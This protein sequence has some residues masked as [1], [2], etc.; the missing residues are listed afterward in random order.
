MADPHGRVW[1]STNGGLAVADARRV[2]AGLPPSV[3]QVEQVLA[4][5]TPVDRQGPITI[6]PS[7]NRLTFVFAGLSLSVPDRVRFRY[8]LEGFDRDWSESVTEHQAVY[9][10]LG[11]GAY[12]FR[13]MASNSDGAWAAAGAAVDLT[14][15]PAYYQTAWFLML[16]VGMVVAA[17]W[18]AHRVRLR[19][20][21]KHE[22]EISALNERLMKAQEQERMRIAGE[23]H[24]GVMQEMLAAT[25]MLGT[26]K[27]R[28]ASAEAQATIDKVQQKLIQVGSDIRQLS[29]ELHPPLLQESGLPRAVL[30][31]CE[32]FTASS[33]IPVACDADER[34][35]DLSRGAA[36]ALFRIVQEALGNAAKHAGASHI[37]V[38][39]T[40]VNDAVSLVVSDDGAGFD[41]SGLGISGGLGLIMMRERATQ[42][43]GRF[44]LQ[45]VP[46][47][48][49][50]IEVVIPFR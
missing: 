44:E 30:T 34:A 11:P 24:D 45:T 37:T 33:G 42:L 22:R 32:Q 5:G 43:N 12:R 28:A 20:V 19:I 21:E 6:P 35:A 40:R 48:G 16:S 23:L 49:T 2:A 29:H 14:I 13:V 47:R 27:R 10:N 9:T 18:A 7:R 38:R 36:L 15:A 39:L 41:R 31:Y 1:L 4:D 25:M 3:V 50:T 8:R 46:G 17:F 26:A